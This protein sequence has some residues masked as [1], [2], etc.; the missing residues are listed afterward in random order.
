MQTTQSIQPMQTTTSTSNL[1][2]VLNEF[3]CAICSNLI[4]EFVS[5]KCK[6]SF[7]QACI[8]C[9]FETKGSRSCPTCR[10][11]H[12]GDLYKVLACD[13]V[14]EKLV[15]S[16]APVDHAAYQARQAAAQEARQSKQLRHGLELTLASVMHHLLA[17]LPIRDSMEPTDAAM[18][19]Q[20]WQ[21]YRNPNPN[22]NEYV[23]RV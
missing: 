20:V 23:R 6:H 8:E 19:D 5:L 9:W 4:C 12:P 14:I 22:L 13:N 15:N 18:Y 21:H 17:T 3:C 11:D 1:T 10:D 2:Q 7:C 16:F